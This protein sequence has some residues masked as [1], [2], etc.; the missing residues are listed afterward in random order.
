MKDFSFKK[1]LAYVKKK[2]PIFI[3]IAIVI[4]VA[5]GLSVASSIMG[6]SRVTVK[7]EAFRLDEKT[8][9]EAGTV[10][11]GGRYRRGETITLKA[12]PNAGYKFVGWTN[13]DKNKTQASAEAEYTLVV[14]EKS[15]TLTAIWEQEEYEATLVIDQ[16]INE[17]QHFSYVVT[18]Q[19]I[20][21]SEPTKAG[22]TFL[23]WLGD[24]EQEDGTVSREKV[25]DFIEPSEAKSVTLYAD[26]A[27]SYNITYV[28]D[29]DVRAAN[30]ANPN[31]PTTYTSR[32][33]VILEAPVCYEQKDG[34]LTGGWY[35]FDHWEMDGRVVTEVNTSLKPNVPDTD[36]EGKSVTLVAKWKD[37][38]TAVYHTVSED[39]KYVELGHYPSKRLSDRKILSEL[40]AAI[41]GGLEPDA[42]TGYYTYKNSIYAKATADLYSKPYD[43]KGKK[44]SAYY[45][46]YFEDGAMIDEGE[47]YF[48]IVEPIKWRVLKGDP[49]DPNSEVLLL[50]E[51]V[52]TAGAFKA[53]STTLS[54]QGQNIYGGNWENSDVRAFL[55]GEFYNAAFKSGEAGFIQKTTVD[56]SKATI[57]KKYKKK[58]FSNGASCE[59][60][61]YLLSYA[62]L[63]NEAYG[64]SKKNN[65]E[66]IKR[67]G[68]T[69]DYSKVM[70]AY[71]CLNQINAKDPTTK[72]EY[73]FTAWWLRSS[74]DFADRAS[75]VT[76]P[77]AVGSVSVESKFIGIR[78]AITVKLG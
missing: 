12:T 65:K 48:F 36:V 11:G 68:K 61:V 59:D 57:N 24:V 44:N 23:G 60:N 78:P 17:L 3:T 54:Y 37:L 46:L 56:Y 58:S 51:S 1:I 7:S 63:T 53:D 27:L 35:T 34:K 42:L 67:V 40:K 6:S 49:K 33:P 15:I 66:E 4:A 69:T 10:S 52:L 75:V 8:A 5:I 25:Q 22:Y 72:D 77:G 28:L 9:L 70:G 76:G 74:A 14:P 26:W 39:G 19:T 38:E 29:E 20:F 13:G 71:S 64:W 16:D 45:P 47:E 30:A 43:D 21:L 18:D 31:N 62:D 32:T 2:K 41:E 73:D 50:S 55:N